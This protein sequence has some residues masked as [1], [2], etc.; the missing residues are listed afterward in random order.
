[1]SLLIRK[2]LN[3]H[4][5]HVKIYRQGFN[6]YDGMEKNSLY[7]PFSSLNGIIMQEEQLSSKSGKG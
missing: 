2:L 5:K 7:P 3:V 6:V 4:D 1:M